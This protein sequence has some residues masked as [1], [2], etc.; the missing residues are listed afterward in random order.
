MD[1]MFP[2]VWMLTWLLQV[3][4]GEPQV[5]VQ[6]RDGVTGEGHRRGHLCFI[7]GKDTRGH[8]IA[9]CLLEEHFTVLCLS[10]Y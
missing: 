6:T 2:L 10:V 9:S 7:H 1:I 5:R 3:L 8:F 4:P